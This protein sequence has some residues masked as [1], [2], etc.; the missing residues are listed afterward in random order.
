M[1]ETRQ[2]RRARERAEAKAA[3]RPPPG[4]DPGTP[5]GAAPETSVR[6]HV[7]E[8]SLSRFYFPCDDEPVSWAAEWG[9]RDDPVGTEDSNEDLRQLISDILDDARQ[10]W[11]GRYDLSIEWTLDGDAPPGKSV[12]DVIAGLGI[13]LP[14]KLIP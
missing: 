12:E 8:V 7:L 4:P 10:Q 9:L 2:Q 1:S 11:V 13:T 3:R 14:G 6:P 5:P